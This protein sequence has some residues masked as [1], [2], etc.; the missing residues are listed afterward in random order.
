MEC[1]CRPWRPGAS[2]ERAVWDVAAGYGLSGGFAVCGSWP[3]SCKRERLCVVCKPLC[4][5]RILLLCLPGARIMCRVC[6]VLAMWRL[7]VPACGCALDSVPV[8]CFPYLM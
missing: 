1:G 6:I 7:R 4:D 8:E 2:S 5:V 3:M